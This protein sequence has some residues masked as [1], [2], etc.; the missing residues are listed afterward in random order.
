[1][2]I[3]QALGAYGENLACNYLEK[4]NYQI[5]ERNYRCKC[6][7]IDI[8]AKD[9]KKNE[10]VFVEV[11]TRSNFNFGRPAHAVDLNKKK[12]IL[13]AAKYYI[14]IHNIK[15]MFFRFDVIEV[16]TQNYSFKI[17]HLKQI[18]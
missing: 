10:L 4:K 9:N 17:N 12:H 13:N 2:Y 16:F 3:K 6:G 15:N 5:I 7:E 18:F 1:M 14:F 11:K 8:I